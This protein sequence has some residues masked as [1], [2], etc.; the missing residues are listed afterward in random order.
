MTFFKLPVSLARIP[1]ALALFAAFPLISRAQPD[2]GAYHAISRL[3]YYTDENAGEIA[4][5]VPDGKMDIA[6]TIDLVFEFEHINRWYPVAPR[7]IS[8]VP[9]PLE[10]LREGNNEITVSFYENN[11][12]IDSRKVNVEVRPAKT[13]AV[14]TDRASGCLSAGGSRFFPV[15]YT[16]DW[17]VDPVLL[18]KDSKKG[19]NMLIPLWQAGKKG[20]KERTRFLD[21]CEA[22]DVKVNYDLS[23]LTGTSISDRD[24][25]R[26][27]KILR[28]EIEIFRD[29]PALLSW[30]MGEAGDKDHMAVLYALVREIDPWH[31]VSLTL[32]KAEQAAMYKNIADIFILRASADQMSDLANYVSDLNALE[33]FF[34]MQKPVWFSPVFHASGDILPKHLSVREARMITYLNI[35]HHAS[36]ILFNFNDDQAVAPESSSMREE[37]EMFAAEIMELS[38]SLCVGKAAP[39][40]TVDHEGLYARV[41]NLH[42]MFSLVVVNTSEI[43]TEVTLTLPEIDFDT[44]VDVLFENRTVPM[45]SGV[46]RD[47]MDGLGT[48]I[49]R[50]DAR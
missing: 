50:I 23:A 45:E 17:P 37:V 16:C 11:K 20:R 4:V 7:G 19:F 28:K 6:I 22:L 40:V 44:D 35:I 48:K 2:P 10:M 42:G 47:L 18:E 1:L 25:G 46:I 34:L 29:H 30:H 12:W 5:Y 8:S 26:K 43:T 39:V 32:S 36:G 9:F 13:N 41:L 31:P 3:D 38:P 14:K 15:G 33:R 21:R 49:Y 27:L 24:Q